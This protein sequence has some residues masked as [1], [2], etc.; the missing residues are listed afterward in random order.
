[1]LSTNEIQVISVKDIG[2][3]GK[4]HHSLLFAKVL[5]N[6]TRLST[7]EQVPDYTKADFTKLKD[8][9]SIDW[10]SKLEILSAQEGWLL[11]KNKLTE[12]MIDCIPMKTRRSN[13]KPLWM[14]PNVLRLIRKKRRLWKHYKTT[15][16]HHEYQEYLKCQRSVAKII[17][18]AKRKFE[19]KLAKN[20]KSSPR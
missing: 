13:N 6:P 8:S 18:A 20:F 15:S 7:T 9:M 4:S 14:K 17:R 2:N 1:M 11:F 10:S 16:D 19:R 3:L 5:V 12:S